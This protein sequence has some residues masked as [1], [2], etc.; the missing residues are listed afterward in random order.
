MPSEKS[1]E[2]ALKVAPTRFVTFM[3]NLV[4]SE[5]CCVDQLA[6]AK[7]SGWPTEANSKEHE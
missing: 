3:R 2:F 4:Q 1:K 6:L 7:L 5:A